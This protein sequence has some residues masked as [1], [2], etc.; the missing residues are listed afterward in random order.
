MKAYLEAD[1]SEHMCDCMH[2]P[3]AADI[4]QNID[5]F[6]FCSTGPSLKSRYSDNLSHFFL[7]PFSIPQATNTTQQHTEHNGMSFTYPC[8]GWIEYLHCI[9]PASL[10]GNRTEAQ[11]QMRE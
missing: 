2:T 3:G 6:N 7:L 5:T 9:T 1:D 4:Q 10:T 11:S 8:R